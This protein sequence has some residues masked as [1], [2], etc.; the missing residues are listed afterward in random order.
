MLRE[1]TIQDSRHSGTLWVVLLSNLPH[2][3]VR[4]SRSTGI[5]APLQ[6]AAMLASQDQLITR[7]AMQTSRLWQIDTERPWL[8]GI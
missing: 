4:S 5:A 1:V 2:C 8:Q 7:W 6:A 3:K